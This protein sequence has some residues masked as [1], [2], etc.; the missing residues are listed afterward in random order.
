MG[1]FRSMAGTP[2]PELRPGS[3]AGR[4]QT[5]EQKRIPECSRAF[6]E[7]HG[8]RVRLPMDYAQPAVE[9]PEAMPAIEKPGISAG[10]VLGKSHVRIAA[11]N[12]RNGSFPG[13]RACLAL[14]A[15]LTIATARPKARS[16]PRH[17]LVRLCGPLTRAAPAGAPAPPRTG[18]PSGFVDRAGRHPARRTR[19]AHFHSWDT[20]SCRARNHHATAL[21]AQTRDGTSAAPCR[22]P[23]PW[24]PRIG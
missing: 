18:V 7:C 20:I 12:N 24:P 5:C 23:H 16:R 14:R 11:G 4:R 2:C 10:E 3:R 22:D 15:A 17:Q 1:P 8:V 9:H 13:R 21:P 6:L 19:S